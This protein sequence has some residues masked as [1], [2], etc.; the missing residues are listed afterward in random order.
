MNKEEF[1]KRI[2]EIREKEWIRDALLLRNKKPEETLKI[3]FDL[4][5]FAA[6]IN[7]VKR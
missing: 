1:R 3:M 7:K 2:K 6:K 5:D 4:C